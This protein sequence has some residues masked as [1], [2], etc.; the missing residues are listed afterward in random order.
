[1]KRRNLAAGF[2]TIE[3]VITLVL[4]GVVSAV[5]ARPLLSLL[6]IRA[7][8]NQTVEQ[9]AEI[10]YALARMA[11]EIRLSDDKEL[12]TSCNTSNDVLKVGDN[13]YSVSDNQLLLN[14]ETF[15]EIGINTFECRTLPSD[16]NLF[17]ELGLYELTI[18][19]TNV[20]AFK[21]DKL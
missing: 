14:G 17:N 12:V 18:N 5:V 6:E 15:I 7:S 10:N 21:R 20:R 9:Q 1:M 4:L 3:L 16:P 8:V 13:L 19:D 2:T 11:M